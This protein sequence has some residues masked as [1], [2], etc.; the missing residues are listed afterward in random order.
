MTDEA[1]SPSDCSRA[2]A[3]RNQILEAAEACFREYGF[4]GASISRI[5]KS[6]GMSA[7]HIYHYFEN[8]EAII[9]AI[10]ANDL[11]RL[12]AMS[13]EMR[14]ADNVLDALID[15]VAEGV[16]EQ[17]ESRGAGLKL[18]IAAEAARNPTVAEIVRGAD[19][20]CTASL[21]ETFRLARLA[22]G[23]S[24]TPEEIARMVEVIAA[25]FDGLLLRRVRQ[26]D[27]DTRE[28]IVGFQ[29]VIRCL[30]TS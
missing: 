1:I 8:K 30:I 5:S 24:A 16:V 20:R 28:L 7:G 14:N 19:R 25:M 2:E 27:I 26:A 18:E 11:D 6:C 12:L 9:A 3:R 13:A 17:L 23:K 10:V 21:A 29:S 22:A 4:H 15:R